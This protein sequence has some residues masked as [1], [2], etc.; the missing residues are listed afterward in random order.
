MVSNSPCVADHVTR[1]IQAA[2]ASLREISDVTG[3]SIESLRRRLAGTREFKGTEVVAIAD[4]LG[5]P[6]GS[7]V[8]PT[9]PPEL[10]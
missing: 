8:A 2:G 10:R 5:I 3:L 7:L 9:Q 4:H 1:A 6:A